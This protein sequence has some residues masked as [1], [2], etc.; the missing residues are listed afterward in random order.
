MIRNFRHK[1]LKRLYE[2]GDRR[3]LP[4]DMVGKIEIILAALDSATMIEDMDRPSF[5]LHPLSGNRIGEWS[6][7]VRANWRVVFR[8]DDR[9][10][11]D[12]NF[13]D[14]H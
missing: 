11:S 1:G 12:V 13:E 9:D 5:N 2:K 3:K 8:F 4:A 10:A 14:Y 7:T 6:V